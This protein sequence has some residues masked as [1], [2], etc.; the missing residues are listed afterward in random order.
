[1]R[2][3]LF[4]VSAIDPANPGSPVVLRASTAFAE[5]SGVNLDGKEW[6]PVL[7]GGP[8]FEYSYW[9]DGQPQALDTA[10][11]SVTFLLDPATGSNAWPKYSFEGAN[12]TVW[13]G[14]LGDPFTS[15]RKL[16]SG[17]L[18]P[19]VRDSDQVAHIP[20]LGA[21]ADLV[22]DLLRYLRWHGRSRGR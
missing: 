1:M 18:G 15:Y 19:L 20:L 7:I 6:A 12:A 13:V 10:Y 22:R 4:E 9:N 11:G 3:L 21:E 14:T 17:K 2:N 16:W 8:E 5:A